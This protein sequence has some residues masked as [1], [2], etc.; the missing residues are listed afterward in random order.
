MKTATENCKFI[1]KVEKIMRYR[2]VRI[3]SKESQNSYLGQMWIIE[4]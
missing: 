4:D 2:Q 3:E 1:F